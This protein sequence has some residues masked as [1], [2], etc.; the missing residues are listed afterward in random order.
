MIIFNIFMAFSK[1]SCSDVILF[2]CLSLLKKGDYLFGGV[3]S[4]FSSR[5]AIICLFLMI[6]LLLYA[7]K[8][9]YLA[10]LLLPARPQ[11]ASPFFKTQTA[12]A[13][14]VLLHV[15]KHFVFVACYFSNLLINALRRPSVWYGQFGLC[16]PCQLYIGLSTKTLNL[17]KLLCSYHTNCHQMYIGLSSC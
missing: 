8:F 2:A 17:K 13:F 9:L 1:S 10:V 12:T 11:R 15:S 5:F 16:K 6:L 4:D 3:P 14:F 7:C